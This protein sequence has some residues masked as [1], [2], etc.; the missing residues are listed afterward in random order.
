MMGNNPLTPEQVCFAAKNHRLIYKY[1]KK[2][3]LSKE[4]YYDIVVFGY[5]K[6][7]QDYHSKKDL[8][9]YAFST[10]CYRYMSREI[11]NYHIG[12]QRQ[13]R[14][15]NIV[16][17]HS[18]QELPIECRVPYGHSEMIKMESRLLLH[19]LAQHIPDKQMGIVR[20][21]C[22]G[23]TLREIARENQMKLKQV[24]QVLYDAYTALKQ[25]CYI[26]DKEERT[27]EP[28]QTNRNDKRKP[29]TP[30]SD[31]AQGDYCP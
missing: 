19:E 4:E 2:R 21:Y 6:A 7:V 30:H 18:G 26:N 12:E 14:T 13:K 23:E 22:A 27:N 17:I 9:Q 8:Q 1:L 15:A 31:R 20:R 29:C 24:R 5:L 16:C 3:Q 25:L 11:T 28:G 10:V